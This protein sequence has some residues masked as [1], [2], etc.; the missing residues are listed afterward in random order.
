[1]S[2][3]LDSDVRDDF[4]DQ[5]YESKRTDCP[6]EENLILWLL[7]HAV[8]ADRRIAERDELLKDMAYDLREAIGAIDDFMAGSGDEGI[9]LII[10]LT[11]AKYE[12][13]LEGST[14]ISDC[15]RNISGVGTTP[16]TSWQG[17]FTI[18][19]SLDNSLEANGGTPYAPGAVSFSDQ[20]GPSDSKKTGECIHGD[21]CPACRQKAHRAEHADDVPDE[22]LSL[23]QE[24]WGVMPVDETTQ[25]DVSQPEESLITKLDSH[26]LNLYN[27]TRV[28]LAEAYKQIESLQARVANLK[29]FGYSESVCNHSV[30]LDAILQAAATI[31]AQAIC[32]EHSSLLSTSDHEWAVE[33]A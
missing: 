2:D 27:E 11:L 7:D 13:L 19:E 6:F 17:G 30:S 33:Q 14:M 1:M 32:L 24:D 16:P 23:M 18:N 25:N 26:W 31:Y 21:K 4:R 9:E 15:S 20:S 29:S 3:W 12:A 10:L 28:E 22:A 5:I 8:E